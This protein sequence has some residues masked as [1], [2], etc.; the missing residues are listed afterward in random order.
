M[1]VKALAT[2]L[3]QKPS[4][5]VQKTKIQAL[6]KR[7]KREKVEMGDGLSQRFKVCLGQSSRH[8]RNSSSGVV[9]T[10]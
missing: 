7:L 8:K 1:T 2:P 4:K 10:S 3:R 5:P 9:T 6:W